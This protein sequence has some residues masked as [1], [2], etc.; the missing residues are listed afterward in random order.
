M[1]L[2]IGVMGS[3][4]EKGERHI[5][6]KTLQLAYKVG[7][8]IAKHNCV[9]VNGACWGIP[10]E[11]SKGAKEADGFILGVSPAENLHE[12]VHKYKFPTD[13]HDMIIYTG[14]GFK[15]R[16]VVNVTNCD[17]VIIVG[18]HVGTLNEFTIAYDEGMVVGVMQGSGGIADFID[19]II[20][21]ASKRTGA[22]VIY[23]KDPHELIRKVI[24]ELMKR[25]KETEQLMQRKMK[26]DHYKCKNC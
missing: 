4:L 13:V 24:I 9:L 15:G 7:T 16:N 14:F 5:T 23:D 18:G 6:K 20:K 12:H 8:E 25:E 22:T 21:I 19:D 17:A 1:K 3:G 10:Y 2:R 26:I 11:A